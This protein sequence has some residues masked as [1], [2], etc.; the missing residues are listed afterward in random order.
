MDLTLQQPDNHLYIRAISGQGIRIGDEW[1]KRPL[2]ISSTQLISDWDVEDIDSINESRLERLFELPADVF[3]LGTGARQHF[4]T[5]ELMMV[6]HRRGVGVE[7]MTTHAACRTFNVLAGE[8]R[9]VVAA[10]LPIVD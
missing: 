7:V 8:Q 6:F 4:L 2:I 5:P 1:H 3:L 9:R 10:L